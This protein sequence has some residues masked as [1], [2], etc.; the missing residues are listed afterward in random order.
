MLRLEM[1]RLAPEAQVWGATCAF[2]EQRSTCGPC[3]NALSVV[4][5][6]QGAGPRR[7]LI[8]LDRDRS[9]DSSASSGRAPTVTIVLSRTV[10][11]THNCGGPIWLA[12]PD[13]PTPSLLNQSRPPKTTTWPQSLLS[14]RCGLLPNDVA[15]SVGVP[16][17]SRCQ[18]PARKHN[19]QIGRSYSAAPTT[20]QPKKTSQ[21]LR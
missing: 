2:S 16:Q 3:F 17:S 19:T 12:Y 7:P 5:A 6:A 9:S 8:G 15:A 11:D 14:S 21:F 10:A 18:G 20:M 1:E 13:D 4:L